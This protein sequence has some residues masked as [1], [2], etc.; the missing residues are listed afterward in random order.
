MLKGPLS[1]QKSKPPFFP[2]AA[3][4]SYKKLGRIL[5]GYNS[6]PDRYRKFIWQTLLELPMNEAAFTSLVSRGTH[7]AWKNIGD[8][9]QIKSPRLSKILE[10]IFT[11]A[12]NSVYGGQLKG[13][14]PELG[15]LEKN[16][17]THNSTNSDGRNRPI[18]PI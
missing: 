7:P 9:F 5:Q 11:I 1:F 2:G 15:K 14:F 8:K 12:E 10:K 13:C 18:W 6:Y 4:L 3:K 16:R 17:F